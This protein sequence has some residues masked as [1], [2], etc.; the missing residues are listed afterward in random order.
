MVRELYSV[1]ELAELKKSKKKYTFICAVVTGLL[2]VL[3]GSLCFMVN[4]ENA[5]IIKFGNIVLSTVVGW[6]VLY[7]MRNYLQPTNS[8]IKRFDICMYA[9]REQFVGVVTEVGEPI[10]LQRNIRVYPITVQ[11]EDGDVQ[12]WWDVNQEIPDFGKTFI[13]FQTVRHQIVAYEVMS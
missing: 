7:L 2:V 3:C 4:R 5:Q 8:M 9:T 6:Y 13:C 11:G 1:T 10:T 12:L